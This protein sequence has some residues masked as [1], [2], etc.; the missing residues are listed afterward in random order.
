MRVPLGKK[1]YKKGVP[2][3]ISKKIWIFQDDTQ[4]LFVKASQGE[5][6]VEIS[7]LSVT[8]FMSYGPLKKG[9]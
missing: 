1:N 6:C 9:A 4:K 7:W 2:N 5:C 3:I 8:Y